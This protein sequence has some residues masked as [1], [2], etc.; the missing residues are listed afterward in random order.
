MQK[1]VDYGNQLWEDLIPKLVFQT[2]PSAL[3]IARVSDMNKIFMFD[4]ATFIAE[5]RLKP[6]F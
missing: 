5:A 2:S 3:I 4:S 6:K 1:N